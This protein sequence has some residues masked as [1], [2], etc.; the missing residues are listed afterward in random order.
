VTVVDGQSVSPASPAGL[1]T[2]F[3]SPPLG[4]AQPSRSPLRRVQTAMLPRTFTGTAYPSRGASS[5][6]LTNLIFRLDGRLPGPGN[7]GRPFC[8]DARSHGKFR[9]PACAFPADA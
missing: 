8:L 7:G 6:S 3:G 9:E 1:L 2:S 5:S 4:S